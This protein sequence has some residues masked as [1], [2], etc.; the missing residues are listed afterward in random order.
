MATFLARALNLEPP[1]QPAG[2][3]DVDPQGVHAPNIDALASA[4]IT[5]GCITEPLQYCPDRPVT[6]AQMATFL[7]RA[8]N[9]EPPDQP[10]GFTDV[11]PQGVHAPNIDALASAGI[12]RGCT[13]EPLQYCPDRPVTRAQMAT[14]LARALNL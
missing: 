13:T 4:G 11:D 2:F 6:R 12:T 1:D 3:T 10:A 5:R 8:L 9:L 7:A 14:F